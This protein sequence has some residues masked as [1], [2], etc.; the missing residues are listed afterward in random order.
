LTILS[1]SR[2]RLQI[3]IALFAL[4]V[5]LVALRF[6]LV[7]A[8]A[9]LT[10]SRNPV[11][12]FRLGWIFPVLFLVPAAILGRMLYL[13]SGDLVAIKAL[14]EGMQ[15]TGFFGRRM[16]PWRGLLHGHQVNYGNILHRNRWF[17]VRYMENG[18]N[19]S[20]RIPLILTKR[21]SGGHMALPEK[22]EKAR[23]EA[24]GQTY[25]PSAADWVPA[26]DFDPDAALQRYLQARKEAPAAAAAGPPQPAVAPEPASPR[27]PARPAFGRK[28]LG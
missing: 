2:S 22:I 7:S 27:Q 10:P 5:L 20:V 16:V 21:G 8:I 11:V 26:E 6:W 28:G 19:R 9:D 25:S 1:Y 3:G 17:N 12:D 14:P 13:L 18:A 4:T 23:A 24:L 15:V